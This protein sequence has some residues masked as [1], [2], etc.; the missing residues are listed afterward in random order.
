[1]S[2]TYSNKIRYADTGDLDAFG[3][4]RVSSVTSL[5]ELKH[6]YDNLPL[7]VDQKVSGVGATATW[8]ATNSQVAMAVTNN[9]EYVIRQTRSRGIYQPG[10][11]QIMEASFGNLQLETNVIKRVGYFSTTTVAPYNSSFDGY[12]LESDG[13]TGI[14]SFQIW[15]SGT[16]IHS[17]PST[18]WLTTEYDFSLLDLTKTQLMVT[19]FQW[20]GVGR[21]RFGMVVDGTFRLLDTHTGAD[22]LTAVY[23]KSPNQPIRYEIR[24][25]GGSGT[26]NMICAQVSLEG[27]INNLQQSTSING[28]NQ[29]TCGVAGTYPL[30]GYRLN[31]SYSGANITL[32]DIQSL[33]GTAGTDCFFTIQ[34]NPTLSGALGGWVNITNT[35]VDYELGNGTVTVSASGTTIASFLGTGNTTQVDNFQF[36]DNILRPG[37]GID[38]TQTEVWLCVT[39]TANNV[40]LRSSANLSFFI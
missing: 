19:D 29:I 33:I 7:L 23:M 17:S 25:V 27:S 5:I 32:S 37:L 40:K 35:P 16:L 39:T 22:S 12:F 30:F 21:V 31:S 28:F 15:Q 11:G 1:M 26:F 6:V 9:N 34:L 13:S 14:I 18:S 24:S 3:R 38:G 20:L 2:Y 10:K 8:S 4:L 36:K